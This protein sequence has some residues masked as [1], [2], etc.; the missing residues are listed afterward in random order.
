MVRQIVKKG[1]GKNP[2]IYNVNGIDAT[3][4]LPNETIMRRA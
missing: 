3:P 1:S 2:M 4:W